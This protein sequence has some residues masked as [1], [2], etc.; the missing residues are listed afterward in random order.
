LT[1]VVDPRIAPGIP[2]GAGA[3]GE[4]RI[5]EPTRIERSLARRTAESRATV[6]DLELRAD[7]DM[8]LHRSRRGSLSALLVK[9]CA[10]ALRAEPRANAAY[11]DG[12]YELYSRVNVGVAVPTDTAYVIA[13][14]FDA[15]GKSLSEIATELEALRARARTGELTP[16]ELSGA[17][18]TLYDLSASGV[19]S[20][21][22]VIN[23]PH[24]A[25]LA[26]GAIREVPVVR[27][28]AVVPGLTMSLTLA[29]D[30]R[31]LYGPRAAEFLARI[32]ALLEAPGEL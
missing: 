11:R 17:T 27:E 8:E 7:V 5:E 4:V 19:T 30:H 13:T 26:A 32:T 2:T 9:A 25:A 23:P 29:C 15:D 16:P 28:G 14:L 3:K 12:R 31:V 21:S 24:A 22:P 10:L 18:I 1:Q 20:A 6:P